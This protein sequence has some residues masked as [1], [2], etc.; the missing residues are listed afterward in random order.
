[1]ELTFFSTMVLNQK[2][3]IRAELVRGRE[4]K[5][6]Q[7]CFMLLYLSFDLNMP[8]CGFQRPLFQMLAVHGQE[9]FRFF[10]REVSTSGYTRGRGVRLDSLPSPSSRTAAISHFTADTQDTR[11]NAVL[12]LQ[13]FT[14]LRE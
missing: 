13:V 2:F 5:A 9:N 6:T 11:R 10:Y 1:M 12:S 4:T 3:D 7:L 8:P 14:D